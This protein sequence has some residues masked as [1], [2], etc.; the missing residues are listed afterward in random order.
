MVLHQETFD[1]SQKEYGRIRH[2]KPSYVVGKDGRV[3]QTDA[4]GNT[5]YDKSQSS[6]ED[7]PPRFLDTFLSGPCSFWNEARLAAC[8]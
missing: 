6:V 7:E 8:P 5:R 3:V 1:S 4:Y 2:D